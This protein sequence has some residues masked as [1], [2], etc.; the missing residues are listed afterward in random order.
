MTKLTS[1]DASP[2]GGLAE[3]QVS[4]TT[5]SL[6]LLVRS[7]IFRR[8]KKEQANIFSRQQEAAQVVIE[9]TENYKN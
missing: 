6:A 8:R 9:I 1:D 5:S 4:K 2:A 7:V 3:A